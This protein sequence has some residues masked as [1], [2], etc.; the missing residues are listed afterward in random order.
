LSVDHANANDQDNEALG[1]F[2]GPSGPDSSALRS[3]L[4]IQI[5][6]AQYDLERAASEA[7]SNGTVANGLD[8][9]LRNLAQLQR[10]IGA[11][12]P[13]TLRVLVASV[14][15]AVAQV[16]S[17]A[18]QVRAGGSADKSTDALAAT[19]RQQ[20]EAIMADMHRFDPYLQFGTTEEES[21]Y[22]KREADRRTYIEEQQKKGTLESDLNAAGGAIGQMVD[23]HAH[24]AGNSP[25]F[26]ERWNELVESTA[27]L[28]ASVIANGG[29]AVEFD[30]RLR[31]ELRQVLRSKRL[32]DAEIDAQFASNPDP[33]NAAKAYVQSDKDIARLKMSAE[34][35]EAMDTPAPAAAQSDVMAMLAN[36]QTPVTGGAEHDPANDPTHGVS[37]ESDHLART[38]SI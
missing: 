35:V 29:S 23:A 12:D 1:N 14:I 36:M 26:G 28:R 24:G 9:E 31:G 11:A 21:A 18:A 10:L 5:L 2:D 22:R 37:A 7:N 32:S 6:G 17:A 33:L 4:L 16:Q 8:D 25:E 19:S 3:A 34:R 15:G 20:V 30:D 13:A 38:R 27:K